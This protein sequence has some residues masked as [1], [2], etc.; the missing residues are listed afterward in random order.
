VRSCSHEREGWTSEENCELLQKCVQE[1]M[2]AAGT[3]NPW[4]SLIEK[5]AVVV[6]VVYERV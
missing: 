5:R 1:Q 4:E 6:K 2:Q 3:E